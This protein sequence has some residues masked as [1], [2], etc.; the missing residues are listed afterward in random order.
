MIEQNRGSPHDSAL[1]RWSCSSAMASVSAHGPTP[2]ASSTILGSPVIPSR[3]AKATR[4]PSSEAIAGSS[5][6]RA[7]ES[8]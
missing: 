1:A 2:K 4:A 3:R 5:T 8:P 7:S 6:S